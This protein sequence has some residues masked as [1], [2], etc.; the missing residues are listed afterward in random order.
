VTPGELDRSSPPEPGPIRTF[1]VPPVV[2]SELANGLSV[3]VARTPAFP[4]VSLALVLPAG[5]SAVEDGR[6][7]MAVLAGDALEGGTRRRSGTDFSREL[8]ARGARLSVRTGWDATVVG[9][10]CM[11]DRL[12]EVAALLAEVVREPAFPDD[13]VERARN[14]Q[15]A[16]IR[17]RRKNPA[18]LASIEAA[19]FFYAKG[20][21]Y[22]RSILGSE[23]SVGGLGAAELRDFEQAR[24]RPGGAGLVVVGDV[25]P[26]GAHDLAARHF[27]S[28]EGDVA[29]GAPPE[30]TARSTEPEVHAV[31]RPGAVQSELRIGHPGAARSP[32]DY[33]PLR[34]A[35]LVLG[36]NFSSRLNLALREEHGFT[37]GVRSTFS[38]RRGPGPWWIR[39][40]VANEVTAPAVAEALS[41]TEA[42]RSDGATEDEVASA[43]DYLAGV[44]PLQLESTGQ[45]AR[46][47]AGLVIHDLPD[48]WYQHYRDRVRAVSREQVDHA[49]RRHV[50]PSEAQIVVVGN[51]EEIARPLEELDLAPVTVHG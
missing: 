41:V 51:A 44:F 7:G 1:E 32:P 48:D 47:I 5:E 45:L 31:H 20:E 26:E 42:L 21:P 12:E 43:R 30:G 15:L 6:E 49:L 38:F 10:T 3:R 34:V 11:A 9:A 40:G 37:Y 36:G 24:Y 33:I 39:T 4:V 23:A 29:R 13:E 50:R 27:G 28:W 14:Q 19:R 8:E 22:G 18:S 35:N 16:Q 46:R 2:L 25:L 17:Q